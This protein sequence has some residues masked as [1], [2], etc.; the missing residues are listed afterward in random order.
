MA[1]IK[2]VYCVAVIYLMLC[3]VNIDCETVT[4]TVSAG[5]PCC[6]EHPRFGALLEKKHEMRQLITELTCH[7][8]YLNISISYQ[9]QKHGRSCSPPWFGGGSDALSRTMNR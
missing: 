7:R 2:V 5:G 9:R 8:V 6:K 4:S 3:V 1:P